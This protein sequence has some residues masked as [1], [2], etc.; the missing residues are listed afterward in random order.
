MPHAHLWNSYIINAP[1][2]LK[3]LGKTAR[4]RGIRIIRKRVG[5]LDETYNIPEVGEVKL[6]INAT[7]LGSKVL[8]GVEDEKVY[9]ARGQ[10][11][12]VHAPG[13]KSCVMS[14]EGFMAPL[15][16]AGQSKSRFAIQ[17]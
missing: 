12:L 13:V 10:T 6:V 1:E 7:G 2:Y 11:V 3:H 9:P 15:P 5:S 14:T 17:R 4:E 16:E 8:I